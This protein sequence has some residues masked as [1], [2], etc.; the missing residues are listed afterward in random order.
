MIT[1]ETKMED[2]SIITVVCPECGERIKLY[3]NAEYSYCPICTSRIRVTDAKKGN[4]SKALIEALSGSELDTIIS[5]VSDIDI[6]RLEIASRKGS[7]I[8]LIKAGSYYLQKN[9][10]S[11][12]KK[13]FD[14]TA[15]HN[16]PDGKYGSMVC[17][18]Y[19]DT[20]VDTQQ[21]LNEITRFDVSS[22]KYLSKDTINRLRNFIDVKQKTWEL[23]KSKTRHIESETSYYS[24]NSSNSYSGNSSSSYTASRPLSRSDLERLNSEICHNLW[25]PYAIDSNPDLTEEQKQQLKDYN[26]IWGD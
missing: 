6:D 1:G 18:L 14:I 17:S 20:N 13:Y 19:T 22:F 5:T 23:Q 2:K 9:N 25:N 10:Y 4:L 8:A 11:E 12:A 7:V 3:S 24:S 15:S 16:I 21:V 26:R